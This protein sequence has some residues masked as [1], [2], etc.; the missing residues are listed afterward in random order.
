MSM[1][2]VVSSALSQVPTLLSVLSMFQH[3]LPRRL[4]GCLPA[5]AF[6][7]APRSRRPG[8]AYP[9]AGGVLYQ[10]KGGATCPLAQSM[11]NSRR[12]RVVRQ[13]AG[14]ISPHR[15]ERFI[16]V[17][18][19]SCESGKHRPAAMSLEHPQEWL[20]AACWEM[21]THPLNHCRPWGVLF[22]T[23]AQ[24]E[25]QANSRCWQRTSQQEGKARKLILAMSVIDAGSTPAGGF[26]RSRSAAS[27]WMAACAR[28]AAQ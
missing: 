6:C 16:P 11:S 24:A 10:P 19:Q 27:W 18:E 26:A 7:T 14:S 9:A 2:R 12:R 4:C 3:H 1:R 15:Y 17:S 28:R 21:A 25:Q 13:H 20:P 23:V 8:S 22:A 5:L